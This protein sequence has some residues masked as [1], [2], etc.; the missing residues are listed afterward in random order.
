[1]HMPHM[2][3]SL[4]VGKLKIQSFLCFSQLLALIND[5][6]LK[7]TK[8]KKHAFEMAAFGVQ[9]VKTALFKAKLAKH[10]SNILFWG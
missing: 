2:I 8:N 10:K 4:T 5:V 7:K 3:P 6:F 9:R 1:M